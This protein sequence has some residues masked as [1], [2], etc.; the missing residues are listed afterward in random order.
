MNAGIDADELLVDF[1]DAFE[2]AV[3]VSRSMWVRS[4]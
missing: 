1:Q 2:L 4:R 3:R